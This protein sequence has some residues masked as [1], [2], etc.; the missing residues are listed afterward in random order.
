MAVCEENE[1][2]HLKI[3]A[4][5]SFLGHLWPYVGAELN[6]LWSKTFKQ[7]TLLKQQSFALDARATNQLARLPDKLLTPW[8]HQP[9]KA[10]GLNHPVPAT[11]EAILQRTIGIIVH[12]YL[13]NIGKAG[14]S[15]WPKEKIDALDA[16]IKRKCQK[17]YVTDEDIALAIASVKQALR[18]ILE[19]KTGRWILTAHHKHQVELVLFS[20]HNGRPKEHII[21]RTFIDEAGI[22]WIID[23]KTSSP[24]RGMN[25]DEFLRQ[26]KETYLPQL[27]RYA[28][29]MQA[30]DGR[31]RKISLALYFPICQ[32]MIDWQWQPSSQSM[33]LANSLLL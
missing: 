25:S 21:D 5:E 23:Y 8:Q 33:P 15:A 20:L 13:A 29:L 10:E 3:P 11:E 26:E 7:N 16:D 19:D 1:Q 27:Q 22:R 2:N 30:M 17:A 14:L 18:N 28:T 9:T 32:K 12:A 31:T 6:E 24:S 4:K